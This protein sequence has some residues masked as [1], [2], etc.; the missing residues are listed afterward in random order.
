MSSSASSKKEP[1]NERVNG[2]SSQNVFISTQMNLFGSAK[3]LCAI[4]NNNTFYYLF[5]YL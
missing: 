1:K 3:V 2:K 4:K 5:V